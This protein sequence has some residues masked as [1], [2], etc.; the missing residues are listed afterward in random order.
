MKPSI[1]LPYKFTPRPYQFP[2]LRAFDNGIKRA[3]IV[4]H[5]RAGKDKTCINVMIREAKKRVGAYY[6]LIP[7]KDQVRKALWDGR[8]ASGMKFLDHIPDEMIERKHEQE[9]KIFMK[10]GSIISFDGTD[11]YDKFRSTNPV[12][13]VFSEFAF[14]HPKVWPTISPILTQNKGWALFNTTPH[15]R[16][17]AHEMIERVKGDPKWFVQI[18]TAYDSLDEQGN[19]YVTDEMIEEE[20]KNM[21]E[22]EIQREYF[23]SFDT[24]SDAYFYM[25]EMIRAEQESRI[26]KVPYDP[27]CSVNT[28][29][30]LGSGFGGTG[31]WFQQTSGRAIH[32]IDYEE[33]FGKGFDHY[34]GILDKKGYRYGRH[35][36]PHDIGDEK[37]IEMGSGRSL[38]EVAQQH[39]GSEKVVRIGKMPVGDG[40]NAVKLLLPMMWFDEQGCSLGIHALKNYKRMYDKRYDQYLETPVHDWASRAADGLRYVAVGYRPTRQK[41]TSVS[42]FAQRSARRK[43]IMKGERN[44]TWMS[45]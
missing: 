39:L 25:D 43:A 2:L 4:F 27:T 18:V 23:C 11:D 32:M 16:N 14:M 15:G 34:V 19:R 12:G 22:S 6:Y 31:I 24:V 41:T 37:R 28:Y 1:L 9:M 33:D 10:N 30:D 17:H 7:R 45:S 40:V 35:H 38:W 3:F 29:W 8:D 13:N 5:R 36:F 44:K 21:P 42:L 26:G 20:R